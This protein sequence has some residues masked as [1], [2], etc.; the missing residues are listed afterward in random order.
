[1]SELFEHVIILILSGMLFPGP[2]WFM[3]HPIQWAL[4]VSWHAITLF[5]RRML[6]GSAIVQASAFCFSSL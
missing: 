5:V 1:M 3:S 2:S 6:P 4:C